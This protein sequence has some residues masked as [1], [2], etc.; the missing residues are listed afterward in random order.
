MHT[1]SQY[2]QIPKHRT[3]QHI[4]R[5][6]KQNIL[7]HTISWTQH[8]VIQYI[9]YQYKQRPNTHNIQ[10]HTTSLIRT[11]KLYARSDVISTEKHYCLIRFSVKHIIRDYFKKGIKNSEAVSGPIW[12]IAT[13]VLICSELLELSGSG[14][15][16]IYP[17]PP[18][19]SSPPGEVLCYSLLPRVSCLMMESAR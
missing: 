10:M 6:K 17:P 12:N 4:Q 1:S 7:I 19:Q 18:W 8:P 11:L 13:P 9:T 14:G 3:S 2:T 15:V 16:M 5:P